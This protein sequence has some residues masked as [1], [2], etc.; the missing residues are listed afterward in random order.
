MNNLSNLNSQDSPWEIIIGIE[1]HVQLNTRSKIFSNSGTA[2]GAEPNTQIGPVD[3]GLPG[4]LPTLNQDVLK[5][6]VL[7]G[8]SINAQINPISIFERKNYFYPDL[9][10]GYQISQFKHPIIGPGLLEINLKNNQTKIIRITRAHLEEDAGKSIHDLISYK[11][12]IDLNRAGMPLLEIVS[13]PDLNSP[14]EAVSYLKTLHELV[15]A[16]DITDGNLQE[17]SFRADLNISVRPYG[18][19]KL[20]TRTEIK[21]INS[22]KFAEQALN[23]EI[24][25]QINILES[26]GKIT[27][28]TRLFDSEKIETRP[29]RSKEDAQDYRYFP[30]P[31]LPPVVLDLAW[32]QELKNTLP[33]LPSQ[34]RAR[35]KD[36]YCLSPEEITQLTKSK[37]ISAYFENL[38]HLN[39]EPKIISNWLNGE[40]A[41][42]L[43]KNNLSF[44]SNS[45]P[46][47]INLFSELLN[48][49]KNKT[50]SNTAAKQ[51]LAELFKNPELIKTPE[52]LNNLIKN[53]G[54][55]Q[56]SDQDFLEKIILKIIQDNPDQIQEL[57]S[58]KDKIMGYLIGQAMKLSQ[59][60]AN[61][62]ELKEILLKLIY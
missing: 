27:Q 21:N 51:V 42:L 59:G 54:L 55:E 31:D 61:P 52:D 9:P 25:R 35:F 15:T 56:I 36:Q 30:D 29:M 14:E 16:I 39:H 32:V 50:L 41:A 17:G 26:G 62:A 24:N 5:K 18:Q 19:E 33:E 46:L 60:K 6:A 11:T 38:I 49:I 45:E 1:V 4:S 20:G 47:K 40:F 10:K 53:L 48:K 22:F 28:E 8:L 43:N 34:K 12:A 57:K 23:Y 44:S 58:G 2:F 37:E 7:F 13:E 3:L